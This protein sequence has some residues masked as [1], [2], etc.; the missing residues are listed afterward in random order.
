MILKITH[1]FKYSVGGIFYKLS[2]L[3]KI[4]RIKKAEKHFIDATHPMKPKAVIIGI[5]VGI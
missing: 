2:P 4:N 3:L 5:A 1:K